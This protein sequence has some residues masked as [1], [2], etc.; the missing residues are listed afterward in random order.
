MSV[1]REESFKKTETFDHEGDSNY[2]LQYAAK[3]TKHLKTTI[4]IC[5]PNSTF[6]EYLFHEVKIYTRTCKIT[7]FPR[8]NGLIYISEMDSMYFYGIIEAMEE[9]LEL[10]HLMYLLFSTQIIKPHYRLLRKMENT[11]WII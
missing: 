3:G 6:Y 8:M 11:L 5:C 2:Y 9:V 10:L 7:L 1:D 4:I